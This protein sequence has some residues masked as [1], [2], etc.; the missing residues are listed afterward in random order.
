MLQIQWGTEYQ[1]QPD[2][3]QQQLAAELAA[4]GQFDAI[5]GNHVHVPQP[6][7]QLAGGPNGT[8]WVA[9]GA[10]NYL[11]NQ[12]AECCAY[13]SP[14]GIFP[15]L[16]V[17]LPGAQDAAVRTEMTWTAHTTDTYGGHRVYPLA[18][19][20]AGEIPT[21][22]ISPAEASERLAALL[23]VMGGD[24]LQRRAPYTPSGPEPQLVPR[25]R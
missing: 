20:A 22:T 16:S 6:I 4:T 14:V 8:T 25:P 3:N 21:A 13:L 11:S 15:V 19:L 9:Y 17:T 1:S 7:T 5:F 12:T 18:E 10:G 24:A 23:E 2:Q